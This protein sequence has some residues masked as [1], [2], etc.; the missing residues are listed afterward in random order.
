MK[1]SMSNMKR[2]YVLFIIILFISYVYSGVS[3]FR[4]N[5]FS[6]HRSHNREVTTFQYLATKG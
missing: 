5:T 4:Y 2:Q 6:T 3:A 1:I